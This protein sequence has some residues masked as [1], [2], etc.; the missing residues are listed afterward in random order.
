MLSHLSDYGLP[1]LVIA[2]LL[3]WLKR[4]QDRIDSEHTARLEDARAYATALQLAADARLED[5]KSYAQHALTLQEAVHQSV[6]KLSEL[7]DLMTPS[8]RRGNGG[9]R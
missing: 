9:A 2:G 3:V 1:G 6:T 7:V 4:L 5:A 8:Q